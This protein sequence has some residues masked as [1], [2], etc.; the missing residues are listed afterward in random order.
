MSKEAF[1]RLATVRHDGLY[2]IKTKALG[3]Y[4]HQATIEKLLRADGT[5]LLVDI[6]C[7]KERYAFRRWCEDR[8]VSISNGIVKV[9]WRVPS[10]VK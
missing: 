7:R 2:E 9:E 5:V 4:N 6:P 1:K 10:D 3:K 8:Y